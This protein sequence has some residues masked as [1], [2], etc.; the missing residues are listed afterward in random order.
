MLAVAAIRV[1]MTEQTDASGVQRSAPCHNRYPV[2][3]TACRLLKR[4]QVF[5]PRQQQ[6]G[7]TATLVSIAGRADP[8]PQGLSMMGVMG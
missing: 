6:S 3:A 1:E 2:D 4:Q 5:I 7:P 8:C